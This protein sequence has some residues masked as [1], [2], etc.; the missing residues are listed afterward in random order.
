MKRNGQ[1]TKDYKYHQSQPST[2]EAIYNQ[3]I[4]EVK[5]CFFFLDTLDKNYVIEKSKLAYINTSKTKGKKNKQSSFHLC[6]IATQ[7]TTSY[8]PV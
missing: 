6:V 3:Y 7:E 5:Q 2:K 4:K 1:Y 8:P